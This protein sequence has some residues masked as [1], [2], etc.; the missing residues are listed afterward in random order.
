MKKSAV[1]KWIVASLILS[2]CSGTLA[3]TKE[4]CIQ[5]CQ[6]RYR[7]KVNNISNLFNNKDLAYYHNVTWQKEALDAAK[8]EF[9]SCRA[10]C[11]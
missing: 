8:N 11:Q 4:Q 9:D 7:D 5:E 1:S 6:R 3:E 2:C 10:I